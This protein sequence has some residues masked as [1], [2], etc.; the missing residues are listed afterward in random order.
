[1]RGPADAPRPR[2]RLSSTCSTPGSRRT[3]GRRAPRSGSMLARCTRRLSRTSW[4]PSPSARCVGGWGWGGVPAGW[5]VHEGH[6]MLPWVVWWGG[7]AA[8]GGA[9]RFSKGQPQKCLAWHSVT[10]PS[11]GEHQR[12]PACQVVTAAG[13]LD[14]RMP[15]PLPCVQEGGKGLDGLVTEVTTAFEAHLHEEEVRGGGGRGDRPGT[16]RLTLHG[17]WFRC[18][19]RPCFAGAAPAIVGLLC[20][21]LDMDDWHLGWLTGGIDMGLYRCPLPPAPFSTG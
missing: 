19:A 15:P 6:E 7:R 10:A 2:C 9:G 20:E 3:W 4:R 14:Q 13:R 18:T 8:D 16:W 17:H 1:M 5:W 21:R 12:G 11:P